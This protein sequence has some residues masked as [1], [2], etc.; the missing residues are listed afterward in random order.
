MGI[1]AK[2]TV[3]DIRTKLEADSK[4]I[5][6][7]ILIQLQYLGEEC[8]TMAR[9]L[10]TY[11]D[12]TGNLRNSVGYIIL[13]NGS[14]VKKN[15]GRSAS[16]K[17]VSKKGKERV[18]TGS[19]DGVKVGEKLALDLIAGYSKGYAL[20]VVAGMEYAAK[21]ETNGKDVLSSSEQYA[22]KQLPQM[23]AQL[24]R[25]IKAMK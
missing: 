18:T 15:F 21:V 16:V 1:R 8:V 2:F 3:A 14:V 9:S 11:K 5:E 6:R 25:Q 12:Q 24:T 4:K 23:K 20:I 19:G 17:K 22:K 10:D 13:R 7:A